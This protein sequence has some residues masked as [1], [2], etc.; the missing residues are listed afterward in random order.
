[1]CK[2]PSIEP[3]VMKLMNEL[4]CPLFYNLLSNLKFYIK[5]INRLSDSLKTF[6]SEKTVDDKIYISSKISIT[7]YNKKYMLNIQYNIDNKYNV[8]SDDVSKL[9]FVNERVFLDNNLEILERTLIRNKKNDNIDNLD[10]LTFDNKVFFSAKV[11]SKEEEKLSNKPCFGYYTKKI[12]NTE[13]LNNKLLTTVLFDEKMFIEKNDSK[14]QYKYSLFE[15]N[16]EL[17]FIYKWSPLLVGLISKKTSKTPFL[18]YDPKES[19]YISDKAIDKNRH[20]HI[21]TQNDTVET[22]SIFKLIDSATNGF[23]FGGEVWFVANFM[24]VSG[25]HT[26]HQVPMNCYHFFIVLDKDSK[27]IKRYSYPFCFDY[28]PMERCSSIVVT[29]KKLLLSYS[30]LNQK[31]YVCSYDMETINKN[32]CFVNCK[33]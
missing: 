26:I 9:F 28:K 25:A 14:Q 19:E 27:K 20:I 1:M 31:C 5:P 12:E 21:N 2:V 11:Y 30:L 6:T 8:D 13:E 23:C 7:P 18:R 4:P 16:G 29:D 10:L 33:K 15:S 24:S 3:L 17:C 22:P 32:I